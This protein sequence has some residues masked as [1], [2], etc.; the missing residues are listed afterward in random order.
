MIVSGLV[1]YP[2][3]NHNGEI[4]RWLML[5]GVIALTSCGGNRADESGQEG[6]ADTTDG[7][8]LKVPGDS[9]RLEDT[10]SAPP[11]S[12]SVR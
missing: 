5:L 10:L 1:E 2:Y 7:G 11:P 6:V 8:T 12:D 9:V 4:M 3:T